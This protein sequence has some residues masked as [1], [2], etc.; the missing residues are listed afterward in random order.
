VNVA[1]AP[2]IPESLAS[3]PG[4]LLAFIAERTTERFEQALAPYGL[5]S[6]Y[7]SVLALIDAE[8]PMSQRELGRRLGIDKSPMVGLI[9]DLEALGYATRRR[10]DDDRRVQAIHL[11]PAGERVLARAIE[12]AELENARTF[13]ALDEDEREQMHALLRRLAEA[14]AER[15]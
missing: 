3:W 10:S 2:G 8:G 9:D 6:K 14:A 7:A 11:T 5:K 1:N 13:G 12:Q 4:Y 15:R